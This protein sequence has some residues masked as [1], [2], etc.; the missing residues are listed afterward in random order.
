[1]FIGLSRQ[2][3]RSLAISLLIL[4]I[5]CMNAAQAQIDGSGQTKQMTTAK[6]TKADKLLS[7]INEHFE[8][9]PPEH[10]YNV[11]YRKLVGLDRIFE[12]D[13]SPL[14]NRIPL[15]L[16][17]GRAEEFQPNSW[18]KKVESD[19]VRRKN[20]K[21]NFKVYAY[22]YD[23]RLPL[24]A[25]AEHFNRDMKHL[26]GKLPSRQKSVLIAYSLG[27]LIMAEAMRDMAILEKVHTV[28]AIAVPFHGSPMFDPSWFSTY[29]SPPNHS[30][31]RKFGD[32]VLY[33]AYLL[34][35][36]NLIEGLSWDNYDGSMP[37]FDA[38][39]PGASDKSVIIGATTSI[40]DQ[41]TKAL[42]Q[43][44]V[45]YA[46]FLPNEFSEPYV[47]AKKRKHKLPLNIIMGAA[48][49]PGD[50]LGAI[51]PFYSNVHSVFPYMGQQLAN[52]PTFTPENPE[53]KNTH[54]YRYND[55]VIPMGS[56]L[57]LPNRNEPYSEDLQGQVDAMDVAKARIFVNL[58]HMHIGDYDSFRPKRVLTADILHPGEGKRKPR[59]WLLYDVESLKPIL[60]GIEER[61]L[62]VSMPLPADKDPKVTSPLAM[63][64]NTPNLDRIL[65]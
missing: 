21:K 51:L 27:G 1:M 2:L 45:I 54:L 28:F 38:A 47:P 23:S 55:G 49:I 30:P 24:K 7:R 59:E 52:I 6:A 65:P 50:V 43:K 58:D 3:N 25:Q 44:T 63:P 4:L 60:Q 37:Q 39:E 20:F 36:T 35:K 64:E 12:F 56:M 26:F 41:Y 33:R 18:W 46:S 48:R 53:G 16:V 11:R 14:G 62:P 9:Y 40:E 32:K 15:V 22:I 17:P 31:L 13:H 42:K 10:L 34:D 61:R 29:L 8:H 5:F 19:A 57:W